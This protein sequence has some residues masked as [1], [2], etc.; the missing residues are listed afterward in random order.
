MS[1]NPKRSQ[2]R[3]GANPI[4]LFFLRL[5]PTLLAVVAAGSAGAAN[6]PA[7]KSHGIGDGEALTYSVRWGIIPSVGR[8]KISGDLIGD[9]NNQVLRVTTTTATW[10]LA[11]GIFPFDGRG[12]SVYQA[13]SG[14]LL[15]SSQWS[16]FRDKVVKNSITF[17]YGKMVASFDD[18]IHPDKSRAIPMPDGDP[19]D[20]ILA[21]IQTRYWDLKPGGK[22]D[23]L[24]IFQDQFYQLT[25]HAE[26]E[27][28]YVLTSMGL[29]KATVLVPRMEKTPPLGMFK[30]GSTVRVWIAN[31]DP[32]H[33]PVRF[34]VGFKVGTGTA[35]L[36]DYQPP[37]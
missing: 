13:S 29:F 20:L 15:S 24:V 23:A 35:T 4:A 7:N 25:I 11:R 12:E 21:L 6:A 10:G 34:E 33:L 26:D 22:R 27:P 1:A 28:Q 32:R 5:V 8:I 14:L 16:A 30:R 9:G 3:A 31:E 36:L 18:D 19:S 2:K 37:K 17:N